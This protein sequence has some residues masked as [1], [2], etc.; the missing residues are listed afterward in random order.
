MGIIYPSE[1]S[2]IIDLTLSTSDSLIVSVYYVRDN[3]FSS[4]FDSRRRIIQLVPPNTDP[5]ELSFSIPVSKPAKVRID[6][7]NKKHNPRIKLYN[8][9]FYS[10]ELNL[11]YSPLK[12][13]NEGII[14]NIDFK[15]MNQGFL[16]FSLHKD[17][18]NPKIFNGNI[19]FYN[20]TKGISKNKIILEA[21]AKYFDR[22]QFFYFENKF[23]YTKSSLVSSWLLSSN[24]FLQYKFYFPDT[25]D[26]RNF[27]IDF[28]NKIGNLIVI[29]SITITNNNDSLYVAQNRVKDFL[30]GN[31]WL[32][33]SLD[34]SGNSMFTVVPYEKQLK[35]DPFVINR[36]RIEYY[37]ETLIEY[38]RSFLFI[39]LATFFL[40]YINP[41]FF[42]YKN[43][44]L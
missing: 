11:K 2:C 7:I 31:A 14:R 29:R 27:R 28:G 32:K 23:R 12:I 34:E 43:M 36:K 16:S 19:S 1:K 25:V 17:V 30:V 4:E 9:N 21:R 22:I 3:D 10:K 38:S 41:L 26:L 33:H 5:I 8:I 13:I 44:F 20:L 37:H 40:I 35:P 39:A 6:F 18:N 42:S 15:E 24:K